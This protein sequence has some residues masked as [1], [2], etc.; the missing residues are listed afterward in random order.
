MSALH[1]HPDAERTLVVDRKRLAGQGL[2]TNI[3]LLRH[4]TVHGNASVSMLVTLDDGR[5]VFAE[6][7]WA[8]LHNAV[9]ALAKSPIASEEVEGL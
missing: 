3:G 4:G 9:R 7:T 6:T 5:Q 8:L 1:I 2:L